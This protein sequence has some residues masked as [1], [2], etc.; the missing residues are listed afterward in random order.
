MP[1]QRLPMRKIRDVLRLRAAACPNARSRPAYRG[2]TGAGDCIR[3]ARRAGLSWPLPE[4]LSDSRENRGLRHFGSSA[5]SALQEPWCG[6]KHSIA[7]QLRPDRIGHGPRPPQPGRWPFLEIAVRPRYHTGR[8]RG[9]RYSFRRM[10]PS[11]GAKA[12]NYSCCF[13]LFDRTS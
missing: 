2:M 7:C 5:G 4:D 1:G 8:T 11:D 9:L 12:T 10:L 6:G 3:R 13:L